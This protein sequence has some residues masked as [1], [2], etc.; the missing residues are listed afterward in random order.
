MIEFRGHQKKRIFFLSS[1]IKRSKG[2][3]VWGCFAENLLPFIDELKEDGDGVCIH[4][5]KKIMHHV[6]KQQQQIDENKKK[7][8]VMVLLCPAQSPG[9]REGSDFTCSRY[10]LGDGHKWTINR[11]A[12][13]CK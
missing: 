5:F 9:D 8:N 3:M 11:L 10:T 12:H 7:N 4:F 13:F 1:T 6:I 2:I